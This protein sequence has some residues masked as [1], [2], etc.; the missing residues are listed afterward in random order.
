MLKNCHIFNLCSLQI[1]SSQHKEKSVSSSQTS[2]WRS[3]WRRKSHRSDQDKFIMTIKNRST[4][5]QHKADL[6]TAVS[7]TDPQGLTRN[8]SLLARKYKYK[9]PQ[10]MLQAIYDEYCVIPEKCMFFICHHSSSKCQH[11]HPIK[12]DF[13]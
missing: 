6:R 7:A 8:S 1:L 9:R 10:K 3:G 5:F 11:V 2:V 13:P 4:H 12:T